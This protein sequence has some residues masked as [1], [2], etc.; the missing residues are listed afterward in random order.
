MRSVQRLVGGE[1][2]AVHTPRCRRLEKDLKHGG[3]V[4]DDQRLFLSARTAAD[5]AGR[6]RT[7]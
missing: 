5:G 6:G 3:G 1:D 2:K 7:G 4:D